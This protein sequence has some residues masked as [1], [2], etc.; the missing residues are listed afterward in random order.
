MMKH[1]ASVASEKI[2]KDEVA[3][4]LMFSSCKLPKL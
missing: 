2:R 3:K 4:M 1:E